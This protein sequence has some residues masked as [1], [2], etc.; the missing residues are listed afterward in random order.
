MNRRNAII[1]LVVFGVPSRLLAQPRRITQIGM[2]IGSAEAARYG[3]VFIKA[4]ADLGYKDGQNARYEIRYGDGSNERAL[5][6][7]GELAA[8]KVDLIWTT[9][10]QMTTAARLAT[11]TLPIV[12]SLV[13]DP[14][15]SGIVR[16]LARPE[17]NA[18]GITVLNAE[19]GAK[20]IEL[21]NEIFPKL[22]R[23]G[24]LHNPADAASSV[25]LPYVSRSIAALGKEMM[26][27]EASSPEQFGVAFARLAEWR[28]EAL[29][30]LENAL[31]VAHRKTL[32]DLAAKN[33]WPTINSTREFTEAGGVMSYGA[34]WGDA[35]RRS[36]AYVDKIL[37]G[38]KPANLPV[39][40][41]TKFEYVVNLK[42]AKAMGLVIP[43]A[44][45]LRPDAV[46]E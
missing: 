8:I 13:S 29:V 46:I 15:A 30:M 28:S 38:A 16:S 11:T 2:L 31:F 35:C 1:C 27:V 6:I 44:V 39:G 36:A 24:V 5:Q 19:T 9:G 26:V 18:T 43:P 23:V 7:A 25:Q 32:M 17:T 14:V 12:F 3:Q 4:M 42:A 20:R 33:H 40:Q 22:R 34:D 10:T 45:L 21:L 41:P 37:R